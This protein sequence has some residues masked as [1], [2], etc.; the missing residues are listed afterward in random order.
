MIYDAVIIGGG[1][2]GM[3]AAGRAGERGA[4]VLLLEKNNKLGVKLLATGHGRCNFTNA[5]ADKK[6]TIGVYGQNHKFLFSAFNKFGVND[7][8]NFFAKLGV[9]AKEEDRGRIFPKSDKAG[10]LRQALINYLKQAGVEIKLGAEVKKIEA[11]GKKIV[12]VILS[13]NNE[14][15]GQNFIISTGGKSYPEAGSTG[16][17]YKWLKNLGHNIIPPRP[18][19]TPIIVKEPIV[20]NLEGLSLK[21]ISLSLYQNN[22]KIISRGGEIIFTADGLSGPAIIDLSERVGALLPAAV[23]L[24]IDLKPDIELFELEKKMQNDFHELPGKMLKNY[25]TGLVPP[26]LVPV[27]IKLSHA[28][29]KKQLGAITK[30]ERRTLA[31]KLKEFT[32]EIT[33]LKDFNKAMITAGGVDVKEVDP[34]TMRS[35]IYENLFLAGEV[36]DLDGPSG[37]YNLQ[38]CWSTGYAAGDSVV[39]KVM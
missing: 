6:E 7:T 31:L 38:I 22:K 36:L 34:K 17:G 12:K 10:D 23:F 1:P 3:M 18:A 15:L 26:K 37:G 13:D 16:D 19:L 33:G 14:I 27:I 20:K 5:L 8:I 2:A 32:L 11:H 29:E 21:N 9:A 28:N 39:F 35:R 25:L 30:P 24:K 4:R